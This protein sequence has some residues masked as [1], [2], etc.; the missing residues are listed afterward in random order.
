MEQR[1]WREERAETPLAALG[2]TVTGTGT[3]AGTETGT[4]RLHWPWSPPSFS[5]PQH[6]HVRTL[7]QEY[8]TGMALLAGLSPTPIVAIFGSARTTLDHPHYRAAYETARLLAQA[9]FAIITGG[10][11]GIMEAANRGAREGGARS[12]GLPIR[13]AREE[14]P[15][16]Y[17]DV[18]IPFTQF[19]PRKAA[20]L[21]AAS[22]FVIF[23]GGLGTLDELFEALC[24]MQA[25]HLARLPLILYGSAFWDGLIAFLR[26]RLAQAGLIDASDLHLLA[27][28]DAPAEAVS[29]V[30]GAHVVAEAEP[31]TEPLS[32]LRQQQGQEQ[33][34]EVAL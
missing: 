13:L 11:P 22:A 7:L 8:L 17:L 31:A 24:A 19:A 6:W 18:A 27:V 1:R 32:P 20:F 15:N 9:G 34:Q 26:E 33:E 21:A 25:G 10:G 2:A 30:A 23:P 14:R 3:G 29:L 5:S 4:G 16:A 12:I 28:A